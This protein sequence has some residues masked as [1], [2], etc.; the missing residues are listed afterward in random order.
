MR[1][2]KVGIG[3]SDSVVSN[4]IKRISCGRKK[5][6]RKN[7]KQES[8]KKET[9]DS[10]GCAGSEGS[11]ASESSSAFHCFLAGLAW[12]L[13]I[14]HFTKKNKVSTEC[15]VLP[16]S[17]PKLIK[18]EPTA[19][20]KTIPSVGNSSSQ[21]DILQSPAK[22]GQGNNEAVKIKIESPTCDDVKSTT[23]ERSKSIQ[24]KE[25]KR[26]G[27]KSPNKVQAT[28][29]TDC[30]DLKEK[31]PIRVV[32]SPSP[33][34]AS[35]SAM[36][37]YSQ[38]ETTKKA[39]DGK[40]LSSK[41]PFNPEHNSGVSQGKTS[42]SVNDS[43]TSE[44]LSLDGE[45]DEPVKKDGNN[46]KLSLELQAK[47]EMILDDLQEKASVFVND[48]LTSDSLKI[49][50]SAAVR[51]SMDGGRIPSKLPAQNETISDN[52]NEQ[53]QVNNSDLTKFI[54]SEEKV[55]DTLETS[56]QVSATCENK[57]ADEGH[58]KILSDSVESLPSDI[59]VSNGNLT[60]EQVLDLELPV[61]TESVLECKLT[62]LLEKNSESEIDSSISDALLF[63][64]KHEES[65]DIDDGKK[66]YSE[67]QARSEKILDNLQANTSVSTNNPQTFDS[68]KM[69]QDATIEKIGNGDKI[70]L[71]LPARE[72]TINDNLNEQS[73]VN[74]SDLTKFIKS[75]EKVQD[76]LKTLSQVSA[77]CENEGTD[78]GHEKILSDSVESLAS[79][80]SVSNGNSTAE[81]VLDLKLPVQT[82]SVLEC[83]LTDLLEKNSE[84]EID[85]PISDA[86]FFDGKHEESK[87]IDAGKKLHSESQARSEK[88]LDDSQE[89]TS[90]STNDP[91]T[92]DS[93]KMEQE[94][95]IKEIGNGDKIPLK[96]PAQEE[97][98]SDNL[99][100]QS[101]VNNSDLTKFIK[102]EEE[103]KDTLKTSS[104][105]SATFENEGA[106]EGHE[107]ILSDSVESLAS[108]ISVSNENS[109]AEQV[110]DLK[111]PVQTESVLEC[112]LTDLR[113]KNSESG[114]YSSISDAHLFDVKHEES[115]DIDDGK[116]LYSE[117]QVRSEKIL[118]NLQANT[119]VST[120]DPQTFDSLKMEQDATIKEIGNGDKI[121]LKLPAQEET[122]SDNLN[123][124]S[125]V[126]NLDLTKFIKADKKVQDT[127]KTCVQVSA[128][129]ENKGADE[130]HEKILSDSLESVASDISVSNENST[131]EQVLDLKLPVQTESV[132]ECKLTDLRE[133][134]S[135]SE[136][137]SSISDAH[138]FDVKHEES[139]D[140]DDGKNESQ[141][142][143]EK[144]LD[145]LQANTSVSTNNPQTFDSLKM[146][147][148]ATIEKI[149]NGDKIPLKLPA[150]EETINDNLNEQSQVNNSDLIKFI[151]SGKKV[152]DT[153]KTLSQVSA[154]CEN[155][156]TDEGHEKILSDSVES[157]ASD[158]SVSNGN[159]TAEQV[160]DLKLPVQT[161]NV[162][163]CKL[164]D[165]LEKNS[166]SEI[167]SPI[168]DAL[169]F[170]GKHEEYKDID[171]GKELYSESQARSE[172][173][174]DDSQENTS[175]ST[176]DPQTF[177]SLKMEQE[178]TIK[179]IGNGYKI[180]LKLPAQEETISDNLN[181]QSQVNNSDLTKFIKSE[182]EVKDTLK[183]SSRVS[184]T[185][186]N[187]GAD[188]GHEKIFS[189][190]LESLASDISVSNENSTAEQ[191]LDLK[192]PV[193]T[194]SVLECKLTDLLEK[195]SES[196]IDSPI[197]DA[198]FF[199]GKHEESK[200][201]DAGKEFYSEVS[202]TCENKGA[203]EGHEKILSDSVESLA[204]DISVS[205][206]NSTAEQ[207]LDLELPVQT[208]SVLECKLTDLLEKNS[209]SG[210]DSPISDALSFDGKHE[211]SKDIDDGKKLYSESQA[212]SEKIL[213]N[214]QENTSVSTNDPQT[215]DSLK[216]V[217]EIGNGDK[218]PLK[219]PVQEETINDN[220]NEQSQVNNS[221]LTK[222]IKSEEKVQE[223][224]KTSSQVSATCENKG[225]GEGH[226]KILS[227]RVESFAS[228]ICV[229]SG[230]STAEQVLDL[231]LPVQIEDKP[232]HRLTD[233]Q[234]KT[235]VTVTES[236]ASSSISLNRE[237]QES[238]R[239][240]EDGKPLQSKNDIQLHFKLNDAKKKVSV[241]KT[242]SLSFNTKQDQTVGNDSKI[243]F[244]DRRLAKVDGNP[245]Q[246]ST[247]IHGDYGI[248]PKADKK[249]LPIPIRRCGVKFDNK[250]KTLSRQIPFYGEGCVKFLE[251]NS[252][253]EGEEYFEINEDVDSDDS[254]TQNNDGIIEKLDGPLEE[255]HYDGAGFRISNRE[256]ENLF[257][258]LEGFCIEGTKF[259]PKPPPEEE[260][261]MEEIDA[262]CDEVVEPSRVKTN[263]R[264][265]STRRGP[266]GDFNNTLQ[267]LS[268]E[269]PHYGGFRKHRNYG[270]ELDENK[271]DDEDME[272]IEEFIIH[273]DSDTSIGKE[274][275]NKYCENS[276]SNEL[277]EEIEEKIDKE[278]DK[279]SSNW[280]VNSPAIK[281]LLDKKQKGGRKENQKQVAP[282]QAATANKSC[283][284]DNKK[285]G[286]GK[287]TKQPKGSTE[288]SSG[289]K[290]TAKM[291]N[292]DNTSKKKTTKQPDL[293]S[294]KQ[295][296]S[297]YDEINAV[298]QEGIVPFVSA[299]GIQSYDGRIPVKNDKMAKK[300]RK[301]ATKCVKF[302]NKLKT[303]RRQ[304]P[305]YGDGRIKFLESNSDEEVEEYLEIN[306]DVDSDYSD[307]QNDDRK[308][309]KL[310]GPLEENH[311]GNTVFDGAGSRIS[312]RKEEILSL[313][314]EGFCIEGTKFTPKPPPE[315]E[316][317][318]EEIDAGCDEVVE[319]SQVKANRRLKT[320]RRRP[321]GDFNNTLQVLSREIPHYG[322]FRKHRKYG[323]ELDENKEYYED[324]ESIEEFIIHGDSDTS[325]GKESENK[326]CENISSN[327][328]LEEIEEKIDK[329][330]DKLSSNWEVNSPAIKSL[331][332]KKQK[333]GKKKNQ[334][335]VALR[336]AATANK[337][338]LPDNKKKGDGKSTKQPKGSTG[339]SSGKKPMAQ[340]GNADDTSKKKA[341]KKSDLPFK[342]RKGKFKG[343][344]KALGKIIPH[345][346]HSKDNPQR[347][348]KKNKGEMKQ[349]NSNDIIEIEKDSSYDEM[350]AV[351][352]EEIVPF[353]SAGKVQSYDRQIP[354]KNDKIAKKNR[355]DDIDSS[356]GDE[357][358]IFLTEPSSKKVSR[359]KNFFRSVKRRL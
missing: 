78:E 101:Q 57:G 124:Q 184:A 61:Q 142:R 230:N 120:I 115:K 300:D 288:K 152:Q 43:P 169:F 118:D 165:L 18:V 174:L 48:L 270:I 271:E 83:K 284:P 93:L 41:I 173:I 265:M 62:D 328:L 268:R 112:K 26:D 220:L 285:K 350:N 353:I 225:A 104:R 128:T 262:G 286:A 224:L 233:V 73:Q 19:D 205:N 72:E 151:K 289:K 304:I 210:I 314:L 27:C 356:S 217:K 253:E 277:L 1:R 243:I 13:T 190:S 8:E 85:S 336:Q 223:I 122:I 323:I 131:A 17:G 325:I 98:I 255:N 168:S 346:D 175:V 293:S 3:D 199:N 59:S 342:K 92:F 247:K 94:A 55:Q 30:I 273:G 214:L 327:E 207:V 76:T 113:E 340:S 351:K 89:N 310:D 74:S 105:V 332:D 108:D 311:H 203:D 280:E 38:S 106:D 252:D 155:E 186:E 200:D 178:A 349:Q 269:I 145:N 82:E 324:M 80:I 249:T 355:N 79:D 114:N 103:V 46:N 226:E 337:S 213:D 295:K 245:S 281:S 283:P 35:S 275:K 352:Q 96:L 334:K 357:S 34:S 16:N 197:S 234:G 167:D 242:N 308:I 307:T 193:Q 219:L 157:L 87:D 135:E 263:R 237:L 358:I 64:V 341:T 319:S 133:K 354:V 240:V 291:E 143:S 10:Q 195:N 67:S 25:E 21:D 146:E 111:L 22:S 303:L 121:P 162:L 339:K 221:V 315:E 238:S 5:R 294:K 302:D 139:K 123:E 149:G 132:L 212:R 198:L 344:R 134:N 47:P 130:G 119:S 250:L 279:P 40:Q 164:T 201:I 216:M 215:F 144:I 4:S 185:F 259:T 137:D 86:L 248:K 348:V 191:V 45:Q 267:V 202:A 318:M 305:F 209:G 126:N 330:D 176:N 218:I 236:S 222:F 107:K 97:T 257:L 52:L 297:S 140:I 84:S 54:K 37:N 138:L 258:Q 211:E 278:D 256:E 125:Q 150:R 282:R 24:K 12:I 68:L 329:E 309:E 206:G 299:G 231:K 232:E 99:N 65:E 110:L 276:S 161:E 229:S 49:K 183:T 172:K 189:D 147:Q 159:S 181:E 141:A 312:N 246:N 20:N 100:D 251:S 260:E 32:G 266:M 39:E 56:S 204:S 241:Y 208:E 31:S 116:E 15:D 313:Q 296:D 228:D 301:D 343:V 7:K 44:P 148:D 338:C 90:V 321:M 272:S 9:S 163:E 287:S 290:P 331:L 2:N 153:L 102:S 77:T 261:I 292:A 88:I 316:E 36:R 317:I 29:Q 69:E 187:K 91:Q 75:E 6:S 274:S 70:P 188:E 347:N 166:E 129:F 192:L 298:R 160:L 227:D 322:G 11:A 81:Q 320:A 51:E 326:Y 239:K 254:D 158:I 177:D 28:P 33:S 60:A 156:G 71:K 306:E 127:L 95:T 180:P 50:L 63:D 335:Q 235:L 244:R 182:E 264:R 179:E 53:S 345:Q 58:E 14:L 136:I 359:A 196:E 66:L 42:S 170:N 117:S 194:E 171:A 23:S 333:G 154:T 109:T